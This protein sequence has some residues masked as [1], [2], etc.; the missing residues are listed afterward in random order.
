M[1]VSLE[2]G[3]IWI[4]IQNISARCSRNRM[5][6]TTAEAWAIHSRLNTCNTQFGCTCH[7]NC[8][9]SP[10]A[11]QGQMH[12]LCYTS[13]I[14]VML[15]SAD[16]ALKHLDYWILDDPLKRDSKPQQM[17]WYLCNGGK[18]ADTHS[19]S[20]SEVITGCLWGS[21]WER[22]TAEGVGGQTRRWTQEVSM[23]EDWG[24]HISAVRAENNTGIVD[25][26]DAASPS[27]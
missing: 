22:K 18:K 23:N 25:S 8:L 20:D 21:V 9:D 4:R 6:P 27:V 7:G 26:V 19:E 10:M 11:P 24:F 2:S 13:S 15:Y 17:V 3:G 5:D 1:K 16:A 12:S 14:A